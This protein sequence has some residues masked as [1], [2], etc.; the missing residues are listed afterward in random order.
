MG[1]SNLVAF[2]AAMKIKAE[3]PE[4]MASEVKPDE[5]DDEVVDF[6]TSS[7]TSP[8]TTLASDDSAGT[9]GGTTSRNVSSPVVHPIE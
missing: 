9:F 6:S 1:P 4:P 7:A 8:N 2:A 5:Y 3:R